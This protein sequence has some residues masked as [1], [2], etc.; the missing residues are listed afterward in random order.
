MKI[1]QCHLS[2]PLKHGGKFQQFLNYYHL[3][4]YGSRNIPVCFFGCYDEE[5][6]IKKLEKHKSLAV[7]IWTG[8]DALRTDIV[9]RTSLMPHVRHIAISSYIENDLTKLNIKDYKFVPI[10]GF[11]ADDL[12]PYQLGDELYTYIPRPDKA[13]NYERYGMS[14]IEEVKNRCNFK[15]N[16]VTDCNKYT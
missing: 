5:G 9:L 3:R 6:D 16:V 14:I 8:G 1:H 2:P 11:P 12:K 7:I 13:K 15:I 10:R 4:K